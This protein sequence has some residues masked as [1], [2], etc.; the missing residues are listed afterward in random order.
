MESIKL[1]YESVPIGGF[2]LNNQLVEKLIKTSS[3][4]FI[5]AIK[6]AAPVI[7]SLFLTNIALGI[8]ARIVPQMN[9][10]IIGFPLKIGVG[11]LIITFMMPF[12][13]VIFKKL[14]T[15]FEFNVVELIRVM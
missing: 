15:A 14:L 13:F 6:I 11:L 10:F 12:I 1:S 5:I 4:I 2:S 7:I 8:L 3:I 9:I